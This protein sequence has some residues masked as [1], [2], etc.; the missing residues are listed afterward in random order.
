MTA[1][2][3]LK[4]VLLASLVLALASVEMPDNL[5][6]FVPDP[7]GADSYPIVTFSWILLQRHYADPARAHSL[8]DLL[9]WTLK[10]GQDLARQSGYVALPLPIREKALAALETI[11]PK[12]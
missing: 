9:V 4:P 12:S 5:R 10:D 11:E 8:R 6:A 2:R 1:S 7:R 3:D